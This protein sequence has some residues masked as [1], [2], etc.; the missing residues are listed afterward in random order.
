MATSFDEIID[1]GLIV[2][3]DYKLNKLFTQDPSVFMKYCDG[4]LIKAIP[5]FTLCQQSLE[6]I[7]DYTVDPPVREFIN[8]LTIYEK[9]IL[10]DYWAIEWFT[11]EVQNASQIANKLQN[12][13]SF[14]N[15][16]EAQNLKAKES[17]LDGLREKVSQKCTDYLLM[18]V[19]KNGLEWYMT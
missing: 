13:G 17:Y 14:K 15:H 12:S 2:V 9:N 19:P 7:I 18:S 4:F 16:S 1:L 11:R 5:N 10:A 8:T 6:Y 3:N